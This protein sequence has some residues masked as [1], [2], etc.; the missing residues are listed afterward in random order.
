MISPAQFFFCV[1]NLNAKLNSNLQNIGKFS[2]QNIGSAT[3]HVLIQ[4]C[5]EWAETTFF[6]P[7]GRDDKKE[8]QRSKVFS[9][10]QIVL[11]VATWNKTS[12][13]QRIIRNYA[14]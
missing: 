3:F 4:I 2:S 12:A 9:Q 6:S 14:M 8:S 13:M 1:Y 5:M 11:D 10:K 7:K